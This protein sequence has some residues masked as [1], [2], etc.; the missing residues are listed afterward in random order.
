M[1]PG[2]FE[3]EEM[4]E[5]GI[6]PH[7]NLEGG[8]DDELGTLASPSNKAATAASN[9]RDYLLKTNNF[10]DDNHKIPQIAAYQKDMGMGNDAIGIVGPK[11]RAKAKTLG[12]TLPEKQSGSST[13]AKDAA[14]N[15]KS[16]LDSTKDFGTK[17]RPSQHVRDY[18]AKMGG[19]VNDGIV[20][21]KTNARAKV[22]GF[23]L[24]NRPVATTSKTTAKLTAKPT[25]KPSTKPT[26][27]DSAAALGKYLTRTKDFGTK[28]KP[29]ATVKQYQTYMGGLQNDGIVGPKTRARAQAL[30]TTLPV[31]PTPAKPKSVVS[32]PKAKT[33][34]TDARK[35]SAAGLRD[36][37][38]KTSDF[39]SDAHKSPNVIAY[40]KA[41]GM[42]S[43]SIGIVGPLT[44]ALATKLGVTLP[45]KP[46]TKTNA[47]KPTRKLIGSDPNSKT[48]LWT[49]AE[50]LRRYLVSTNDFGS[51]AKPSSKVAEFQKKM[52]KL[53]ADGIV[54]PKTRARA[55]ELNNIILPTAKSSTKHATKKVNK[56][57]NKAFNE[58]K[59]K[60]AS[61]LDAHKKLAV[62]DKLTDKYPNFP[63]WDTFKFRSLVINLLRQRNQPMDATNKNEGGKLSSN[64]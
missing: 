48:P 33:P 22:L 2:D 43:Q 28:A 26:P 25:A 58:A 27:K 57:I 20:G 11:T 55:K 49:Y 63:L 44:R 51:K 32:K 61:K 46:A 35:K 37:L 18:Q 45:P 36:Y 38:V 31:A 41:M 23:T 42:G 5:L 13:I 39:G 14:K 19:L 10:G 21:P 17:A 29:S 40:Q 7:L 52:G 3:F 54:G 62:I 1:G 50:G 9:L 34:S 6:D 56:H 4:D 64:A 16:Y 12:V 59:N 24:P 60:H 53:V 47:K 15:L 8:F 30:G